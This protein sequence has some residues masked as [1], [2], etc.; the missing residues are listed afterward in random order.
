MPVAGCRKK[1]VGT[2]GWSGSNRQTLQVSYTTEKEMNDTGGL[3]QG[4][5]KN[6]GAAI[7]RKGC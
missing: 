6:G 4:D 5:R 2:R 7:T 3:S 1:D